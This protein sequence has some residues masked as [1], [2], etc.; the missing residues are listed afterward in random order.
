MGALWQCMIDNVFKM[1]EFYSAEEKGQRSMQRM[2]HQLQS[3]YSSFRKANPSVSLSEVR[4]ISARLLGK[5]GSQMLQTKAAETDGLLGFAESL[6][7]E[8]HSRM[9]NGEYWL[10][11]LGL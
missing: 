10:D 8:H 5:R 7:Q 4:E 9:R 11:V 1:P 6:I 2:D 3:Y